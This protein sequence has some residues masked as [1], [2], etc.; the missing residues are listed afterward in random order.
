MKGLII[1]FSVTFNCIS[2]ITAQTFIK[3]ANI[4]FEVKTNIKKTMGES[5]WAEMIKDNLPNFKTAYYEYTFSDNKSIYKFTHLDEKTKLPD[6]MKKEDE[7][8][9]WYMDFDNRK[10]EVTQDFPGQYPKPIML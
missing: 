6:F 7:S 5:M 4:E 2:A 9:E 10:I 8:N 3:K 1:F